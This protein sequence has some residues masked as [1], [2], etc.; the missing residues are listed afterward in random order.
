MYSNVP[1]FVVLDVY[2]A[3]LFAPSFSDFDH[4]T[5]ELNPG[6][7]EQQVISPFIWPNGTGTASSI[8]WYAA[9][10][11]QDYTEFLGEMSVFEFGWGE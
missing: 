2:G 5:I 8:F 6:V 7:L 10:T 4:W 9:M 11:S 3:Y 1:L